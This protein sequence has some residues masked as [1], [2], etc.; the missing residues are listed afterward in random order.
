MLAVERQD[1][2]LGG[3]EAGEVK[4]EGADGKLFFET[5]LKNAQEGFFA[6]PI[7]GGNKDMCGWKMIGYPGARYD[8]RDWVGRHNERYPYPP[9]SITGRPEWTPKG[10]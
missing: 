4:L 3:L 10:T 9:V 5:L 7:Y 8:Y 1:Q 6:D 2:L